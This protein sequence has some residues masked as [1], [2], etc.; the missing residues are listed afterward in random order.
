MAHLWK[1]D[2]AMAGSHG[3][4]H[5]C[6]ASSFREKGDYY[7]SLPLDSAVR[8]TDYLT[9]EEGEG[10]GG[11]RRKVGNQKEERE[12]KR[13]GAHRREGTQTADTFQFYHAG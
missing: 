9:E 10:W 2:K 1:P 7:G 6:P 12:R 5:Q 4:P 8:P 13:G 3:H 11:R